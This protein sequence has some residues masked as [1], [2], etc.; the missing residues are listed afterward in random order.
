MPLEG[1][2]ILRKSLGKL[3]LIESGTN[4]YSIF[5]EGSESG[6]ESYTNAAAATFFVNRGSFFDLSG[7]TREELTTFPMNWDIAEDGRVIANV[8]FDPNIGYLSTLKIWNII[9]EKPITDDDLDAFGSN[10]PFYNAPGF[11]GSNHELRGIVGAQWREYSW[12]QGEGTGYVP[13]NIDS[14][15]A[16]VVNSGTWGL[17][18]ATTVRHLYITIIIQIQDLTGSAMTSLQY[19]NTAWSIGVVAGEEKDLVYIERLRRSWEQR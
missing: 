10:Y 17:C 18:Q 15:G 12:T 9:S 13:P 3:Q 5:N 14:L 1:A 4:E 11:L 16:R 6:W 19:P 8:L 2:H 7:Y